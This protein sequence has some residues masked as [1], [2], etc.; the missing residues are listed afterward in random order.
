MSIIIHI[1]AQE[2][3]MKKIAVFILF[4]AALLIAAGFSAC[5]AKNDKNRSLNDTLTYMTKSVTDAISDGVGEANNQGQASGNLSFNSAPLELDS[6]FTLKE[7]ILA[8]LRDKTSQTGTPAY[9][10]VSPGPL[11]CFSGTIDIAPDYASTWGTAS[12]TAFQMVRTFNS[13]M[14][15]N[16]RHVIDG[17]AIHDW[18]GLDGT[19]TGGAKIIAGTIMRQVPTNKKITNTINYRYA[20]MSG[21]SAGETVSYNLQNYNTAHKLVYVAPTAGSDRTFNM[22]ITLERRIYTADNF[23]R[24][25]HVVTTSVGQ[26]VT[27]DVNLTNNTRTINGTVQVADAVSNYSMTAV[28]TNVTHAIGDCLPAS[29]TIALTLTGKHAGTG[30]LTF[31]GDG[32]AAYT[33]TPMDDEETTG[34][35][36]MEGCINR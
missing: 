3:N 34:T 9:A 24:H 21:T 25:V 16:G 6:D 35:I 8:F 1:S 11:T 17:A 13:C 32:T 14:R 28:Y 4:F 30:T 5:N 10:V 33:F 2:M 15:Y 27:V 36:D 23:L 29:G 12:T 20:I 18:T 26:P 31:N 7:T 19:Q 22:T